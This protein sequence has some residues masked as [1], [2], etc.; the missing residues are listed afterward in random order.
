M[1]YTKS[2]VSIVIKYDLLK[3]N[4]NFSF[5]FY[6][7]FLSADNLN[8]KE[9]KEAKENTH[10]EN[11]VVVNIF[12]GLT[13]KR[14]ADESYLVKLLIS[15]YSTFKRQKTQCFNFCWVNETLSY[16]LVGIGAREFEVIIKLCCPSNYPKVN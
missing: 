10:I 4:K 9:K 8:G 15:L 1:W 16:I 11:V 7:I 5:S 6:F 3:L 12:D 14:R 2:N 13:K